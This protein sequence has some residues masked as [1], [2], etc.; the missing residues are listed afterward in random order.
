[1]KKAVSE[2]RFNPVCPPNRWAVGLCSA[3]PNP[4][5]GLLDKNTTQAGK[6]DF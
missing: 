5:A 6:H 4:I 1:M 2:N 3:L